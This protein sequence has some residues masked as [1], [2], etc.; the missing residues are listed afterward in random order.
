V[1]N[2]APQNKVAAGGIGGA[3]S[4]VALWL[5]STYLHFN[6]PPDVA[7]AISMLITF[8][9]GYFTPHADNET[10]P[11]GASDATQKGQP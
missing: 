1:T 7:G 4:I 8:G 3:V 11:S 6:P 2:L 9:V 5:G 10:L